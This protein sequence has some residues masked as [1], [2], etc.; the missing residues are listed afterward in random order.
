MSAE[1]TH[2][3][4]SNG[5]LTPNLGFVFVRLFGMEIKS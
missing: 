1:K 4:P 5:L 3:L 2:G